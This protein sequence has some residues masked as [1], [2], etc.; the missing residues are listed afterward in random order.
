MLEKGLTPLRGTQQVTVRCTPGAVFRKSLLHG[1]GL[2]SI[3]RL[4]F[5]GLS[6]AETSTS[7]TVLLSGRSRLGLTVL[8]LG[9]AVLLGVAR[10]LEPSPQGRGT[11]QQL[12]L[13]P[14]TFEV[15]SAG[16]VQPAG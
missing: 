2:P 14:C 12:G 15:L 13:P 3:F 9:L 11:H 5:T 1:G 6:V 7:R 8:A 10:A 16:R 4:L